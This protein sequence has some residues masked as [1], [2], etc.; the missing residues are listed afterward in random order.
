MDFTLKVNLALALE[1]V[2]V[3]LRIQFKLILK[4]PDN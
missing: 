3:S 1:D 2:R 4:L